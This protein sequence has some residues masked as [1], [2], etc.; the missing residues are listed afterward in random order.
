MATLLAPARLQELKENPAAIFGKRELIQEAA[1][2]DMFPALLR[3]G[4]RAIL[5]DSFAGVPTTYQDLVDRVPSDK[6]EE[7]WT[8]LERG[9]TLPIV[10]EGQ[11]YP[12]AKFGQRPPRRI[13]NY[14]RGEIL[15]ITEELLR[16]DR[17]NQIR[18][19]AQD[20][21]A[22][23]AQTR[24]QSF[25]DVIT[26]TGNYTQTSAT[27]DIGN[28]TNATT[29]GFQGLELAHSTLVTMKD[30]T[31]GRYFGVMPDTVIVTP[32]LRFAAG[33]MLASD[34]L[35]YAM[36]GNTD[37]VPIYGA[38]TRNP[39]RDLNLRV[40]VSPY[41]GTSYQWCMMAARRAVKWQVIEDMTILIQDALRAEDSEAY[42][43]FDVVRYRV[44][45]WWGMGM[46][47]DRF[48]YFSSSTTAPVV[49]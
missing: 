7:V 26:A 38:G 44:R 31:S 18:Q 23:V 20:F 16:F 19:W 17:T 33:Q 39:F 25:Y 14:K 22:Q 21:G 1:R 2:T 32:R 34:R 36:A 48:A 13:R 49:N 46:Y 30:R 24:E 15:E 10:G 11:E 35:T 45:D 43:L 6:D 47:D 29:F 4:I 8:E 9:G 28:N 3:D 12:R 40:V 27:N 41:M 5:F 42:F 37:N